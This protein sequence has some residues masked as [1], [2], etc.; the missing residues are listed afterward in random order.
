VFM[1]R[2][3]VVAALFA[4]FDKLGGKAAEFWD[5]VANGL[6]ISEKTDPRYMLREYLNTHGQSKGARAVASTTMFVGAEDTYRICISAWN[7]WRTGEKQSRTYQ[8]LEKR[9][10][11]R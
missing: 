6:G 5:P 8:T 11:P 1:K 10:K 2:A 3:G 7:K 4:T 9:V